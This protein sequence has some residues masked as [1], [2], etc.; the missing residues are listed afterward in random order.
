MLVEYIIKIISKYIVLSQL[1]EQYI[2]RFATNG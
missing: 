1:L 2:I